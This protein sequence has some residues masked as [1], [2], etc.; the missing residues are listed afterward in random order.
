VYTD[1]TGWTYSGQWANGER[2]GHGRAD[3]P[4]GSYC[5]GAWAHDIKQGEGA[6][7]YVDEKGRYYGTYSGSFL[8]NRRNG[9]GTLTYASGYVQQG[10]WQNDEFMS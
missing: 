6:Q 3:Y 10:Q 7:T 2:N 9:Y 8:N 5:E 1:A 4:G